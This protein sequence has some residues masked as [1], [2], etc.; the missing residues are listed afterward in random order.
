[1]QFITSTN[2]II[3]II[4]IMVIRITI[5]EAIHLCCVSKC[6]QEKRGAKMSTAYHLSLGLVAWNRNRNGNGEWEWELKLPSEIKHELGYHSVNL[7]PW[8]SNCPTVAVPCPS[9]SSVNDF[10]ASLNDSPPFGCRTSAYQQKNAKQ[11][12]WDKS[13]AKMQN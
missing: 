1:M 12:N 7:S 5:I 2:G 8:L 6:G 10:S 3:I 13:K 9:S 4:I 11:S